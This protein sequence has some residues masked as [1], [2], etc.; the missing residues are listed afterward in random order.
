MTPDTVALLAITVMAITTFA[1]RYGGF[2]IMSAVKITPK[3]EMFLEKMSVS[4][5]VAIVASAF[6]SGGMRTATAVIIG[7][8]VMLGTKSPIAAMLI[9]IAIG[10]L[11]N[12]W[13]T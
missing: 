7:V 10:A 3:I 13:L 2:A 9:G 11:W 6:V 4:V 1:L 8:A 5:L 12:F